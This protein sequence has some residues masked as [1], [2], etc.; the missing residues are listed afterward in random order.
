[1]RPHQF[2]IKQLYLPNLSTGIGVP[3]GADPDPLPSV[4]S[5]FLLEGYAG[6]QR[7]P[8]STPAYTLPEAASPHST[9]FPPLSRPV[10]GCP[11]AGYHH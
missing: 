1:M 7:G 11:M 6:E 4:F 2:R 9:H 10:V 8:I 3:I 5:G